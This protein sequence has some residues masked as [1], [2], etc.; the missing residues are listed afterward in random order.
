MFDAVALG[1]LDIAKVSTDVITTAVPEFGVLD[2]PYVFRDLNHMMAILKSKVGQD[3]TAKLK[4]RNVKMLFWME[5]GR[6]LG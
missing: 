1:A 5:Q 2:L 4:A 6:E 3:L